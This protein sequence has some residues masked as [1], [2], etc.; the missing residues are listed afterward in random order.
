MLQ[1]IT[2]VTGI[3]GPSHGRTYRLLRLAELTMDVSGCRAYRGAGGEAWRDPA[4][5]PCGLRYCLRRLGRL[6]AA[7]ASAATSGLSADGAASLARLSRR[8]DQC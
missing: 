6:A 7:E 4:H 8:T 2:I 1:R 5:S 3:R